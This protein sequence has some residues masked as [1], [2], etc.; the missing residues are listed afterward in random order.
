MLKRKLEEVTNANRRLKE[1]SAQL[2]RVKQRKK[3]SSSGAAVGEPRGSGPPQRT[4]KE[5]RAWLE[6]EMAVYQQIKDA[7]ATLA[8]ETAA[9]AHNLTAIEMLKGN[10]ERATAS[11]SSADSQARLTTR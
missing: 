10:L 3:P 5:K 1:M 4:A 7:K 2:A 6:E 11:G 8:A 9:H